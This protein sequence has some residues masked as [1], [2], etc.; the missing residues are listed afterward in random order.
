MPMPRIVLIIDEFQDLF[1]AD[2]EIAR[3]AKALL[4]GL[5]L[6]GRSFGIHVI[7]VSQS[8]GGSAW[9]LGRAVFDQ[10]AI[11]IALP[12]SEADSRL[13][14][15]DD[16]PAAR[17]LTRPGEAIYNA[18]KGLPS[19]NQTFQVALLDNKEG[20]LDRYLQALV[21]NA[22]ATMP[23]RRP[24]IF[25]GDA[26]LSESCALVQFC[27]RPLGRRPTHPSSSGWASRWQWRRRRPTCAWSAPVAP[28]SWS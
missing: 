7:L 3:N 1:A 19:G 17:D 25:D 11:R 14:L 26:E 24:R 8:L 9:D 5:V 12:C 23:G 15:A 16:N 27:R 6:K 28:T 21:A 18:T 22:D 20:E 10:M 13:I 4:T 2:D